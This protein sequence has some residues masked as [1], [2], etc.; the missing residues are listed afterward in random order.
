M[1]DEDV[2]ADALADVPDAEGGVAGAGDGEVGAGHLQ[3]PDGAG[4]AAE[5]VL[6]HARGEVPDADVAVAAAGDEDVAVG[7]HGPDAHDVALEAAEVAAVR[8]EDVDLGVVE[9]DDDVG[10][11]EVE[12][13]DDALVRGDLAGVDFAASAPGGFDLVA[14][15][16]VGA[17]AGSFWSAFCCG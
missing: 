4:V 3:T 15:F 14:L 6:R 11:G 16:E 7:D 2:L 5:H 17:V 9:G 1:A 10:G 8:V 13:S 12:G